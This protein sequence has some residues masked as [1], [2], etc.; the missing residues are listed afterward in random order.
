MTFAPTRS[1][2]SLAQQRHQ[3]GI[4]VGKASRMYFY[5]PKTIMAECNIHCETYVGFFKGVDENMGRIAIRRSYEH[6]SYLLNLPHGERSHTYS[7]SIPCAC[8][9]LATVPRPVKDVTYTV[10]N[11]T[12]I[13]DRPCEYW[14][15]LK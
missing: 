2:R 13:L 10:D 1:K 5:L 15:W 14:I 11:R 7:V 12:L 4:S 9:D 3:P 8:L 6:P